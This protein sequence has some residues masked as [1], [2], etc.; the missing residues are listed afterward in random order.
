MECLVCFE[1]STHRMIA[2]TACNKRVCAACLRKMPHTECPFCR[3]FHGEAYLLK[4]AW[5]VKNTLRYFGADVR[6][7]VRERGEACKIDAD[8]GSIYLDDVI[9]R[10]MSREGYK[11]HK[12]LREIHEYM[13]SIVI[14]SAGARDGMARDIA[15]G[16]TYKKEVVRQ[17][18][19]TS[20]NPTT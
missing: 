4:R 9:D 14:K 18:K 10:L 1:K 13:Y 12:D 15:F 11:V 6:K 17:Q 5:F 7:F 20:C 8:G 19:E 3:T 16:N 2:C